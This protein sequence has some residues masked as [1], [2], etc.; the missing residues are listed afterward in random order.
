VPASVQ[1]GDWL[2]RSPGENA[3]GGGTIDGRIERAAAF[4]AQA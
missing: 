3:Y 2:S 4:F 1:S